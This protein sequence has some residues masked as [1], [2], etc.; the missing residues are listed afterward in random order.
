[1]HA[2][3]GVSCG[4]SPDNKVVSQLPISYHISL[5]KLVLK[6]CSGSSH[7]WK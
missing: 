2:Y 6:D 7:G 4:Q 3:L 1:M 5:L